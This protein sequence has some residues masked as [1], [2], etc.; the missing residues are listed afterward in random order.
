[1][2]N[3]TCP[4]CGSVD[5]AERFSV[6]ERGEV[7]DP[8]LGNPGFTQPCDDEWHATP[9]TPPAPADD[10]CWKC[11]G[12]VEQVGLTGDEGNDDG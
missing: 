11:G 7:R 2:S 12:G 9:P 4:T 10:K 3:E 8:F 6:D 1:M 5:R